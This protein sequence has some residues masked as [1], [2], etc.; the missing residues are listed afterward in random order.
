MKPREQIFIDDKVQ[1]VLNKICKSDDLVYSNGKP[2]RT[3]LLALVLER[4]V[5]DHVKAKKEGK[6]SHLSALIDK[7]KDNV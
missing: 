7:V 3:R 2:K 4:L 1:N 5:K 6:K